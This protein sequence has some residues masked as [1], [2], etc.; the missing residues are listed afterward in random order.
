MG[1]YLDA[2]RRIRTVMDTAGAMLTDEQALTV[3]AL[4]PSWDDSATYTV[5]QRVRYA[6]ILYKCLTAHTA[7]P[8]WPPTAS[9]SLWAKV[10][11][12][13]AGAILPW[14]QPGSANAYMTGDKV[15]YDGKTWVSIVDDNVWEPGVY[16]WQEVDV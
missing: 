9:P 11:I 5:G 8:G 12:D 15:T 4:Y 2:A 16:G 1:R 10:L 13:P 14:E 6:G 3:T 7:Q